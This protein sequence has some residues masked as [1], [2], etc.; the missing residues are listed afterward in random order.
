M[1]AAERF[2]VVVVGSGC[3]GSSPMS[4]KMWFDHASYPEQFAGLFTK[5]IMEI[6][7]HVERSD[8]K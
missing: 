5:Q 6:I 8:L 7:R 2:D 4:P 3:A 1:G